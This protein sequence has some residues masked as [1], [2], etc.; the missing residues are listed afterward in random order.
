MENSPRLTNVDCR[1]L[2]TNVWNIATPANNVWSETISASSNNIPSTAPP[3]WGL[4]F[5]QSAGEV[6]PRNTAVRIWRRIY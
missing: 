5:L 1:T 3:I 2:T 4:S 6:R